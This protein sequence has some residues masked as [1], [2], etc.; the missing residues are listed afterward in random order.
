MARGIKPAF[1]SLDEEVIMDKLKKSTSFEGFIK[2]LGYTSGRNQHT[3]IAVIKYLESKN[4]DYRDYLASNRDIAN[5][6]SIPDDE[7]F[8]LGTKY[9]SGSSFVKRYK[10]KVNN[11]ACSICGISKWMDKEITLQVDHINGNHYDNRLTNLRFLCPNCHSQTS[12]YGNKRGKSL[13]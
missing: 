3:R 6:K 9:R 13:Y 8:V 2:S 11:Y 12:T 4:I 1:L 5:R 10:N 7:Y